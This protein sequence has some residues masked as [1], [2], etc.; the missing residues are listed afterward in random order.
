MAS[1]QRRLNFERGVQQIAE[2][3]RDRGG[4]TPP[5]EHRWK[6]FSP[7]CSTSLKPQPSTMKVQNSNV[8]P[9]QHL[10]PVQRICCS[11][12]DRSLH[13]EAVNMKHPYVSS[14]SKT[15]KRRQSEHFS[16]RVASFEMALLIP[17]SLSSNKPNK[18]EPSKLITSNFTNINQQLTTSTPTTESRRKKIVFSMSYENY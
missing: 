2:N 18:N 12:V 17:M 8:G 1:K 5:T 9:V 3:H 10:K 13:S 4:G 16:S 11:A 6:E 14:S 15:Q 7:F